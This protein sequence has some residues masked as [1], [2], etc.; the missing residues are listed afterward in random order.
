MQG[1][2]RLKIL[3]LLRLQRVECAKPN[4]SYTKVDKVN[5][6]DLNAFVSAKV[7]VTFN[8]AKKNLKKQRKEK[9]VKLNAFNKFHSLTVESSNEEDE[10]NKHTPINVDNNDSSVS[11]LFSNDSDSNIK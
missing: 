4:T 6:N 8:K 5:Y 11:C 1:N 10:S 2:R 9:E 3:R 7:S